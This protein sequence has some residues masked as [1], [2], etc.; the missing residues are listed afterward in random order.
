M[1]TRAFAVFVDEPV[2]PITKPS[3]DRD[4]A[5]PSTSP[6]TLTSAATTEKENL[7]PVTGENAR[8]PADGQHKKGKNTVLSTKFYAPPVLSKKKKEPDLED[9]KQDGKK[10]LALSS[11]DGKNGS[12]KARR[13]AEPSRIATTSRVRRIKGMPKVDEKAE[14]EDSSCSKKADATEALA[15]AN[16]DSKCYDLTVTPLADVSKAFEQVSLKP[17]DSTVDVSKP[18]PQKTHP[19]DLVF[20]A[21]APVKKLSKAVEETKAFS[22]PERKRI[23]SAFTFS[24][25]SPSSQRFAAMQ[26]SG[27]DMFGNIKFALS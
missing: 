26:S 10:R 8:A 19:L 11:L 9:V 3:S 18:S 25:P 16:V 7:H 17:T 23:Y 14:V 12:R 2:E 4:S 13:V 27:S 22:T 5:S 1:S 20:R 6:A 21:Q 15:Q 24:S